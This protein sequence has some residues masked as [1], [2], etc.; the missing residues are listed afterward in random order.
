[1][2]AV[3][4]CEQYDK[5]SLKKQIKTYKYKIKDFF[6]IKNDIDELHLDYGVVYSG[7]EN[8][9]EQIHQLFS[10]AEEEL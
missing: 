5:V 9:V 8:K 2:P 3:I 10:N 6:Q 7:I 4:F 1:M